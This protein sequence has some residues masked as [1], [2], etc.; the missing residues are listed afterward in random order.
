MRTWAT[1]AV[2]TGCRRGELLGLKWDDIDFDAC[3]LTVRRTLR[4]QL[5]NFRLGTVEES[6]LRHRRED[7]LPGSEAPA[8]WRALLREGRWEPVAGVLRHNRDDLVSLAA[9]YVWLA[10]ARSANTGLF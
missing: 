8:A 2:F 3:T 1:L 4:G 9:L 7:D 10:G 5:P 6:L